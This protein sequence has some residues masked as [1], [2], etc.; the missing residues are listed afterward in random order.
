MAWGLET[1]GE[2][3]VAESRAERADEETVRAWCARVT[4]PVLV[5]QGDG[6]RVVPPEC[7][8]ALAE[9]TG[10]RLEVVEGGGHLPMV[11]DPV[12]VNLLV[13]D[14]AARF[15][16]PEPRRTW[17]RW[18]RRPRRVLYLCS[19][20]GLGHARRDVA[21][22]RELRALHP[23]VRIDWLAQDP[24]TR[25]LEAAGERVHPASRWLACES[26]HVESEAG[27]HD[28]HCFQALR[29]MDEILLANFMV[30]HDVVRDEPYDLVVGDEAWEVDHFLHENP[31][32]KRFAYAWLT[33]FVGMLP[34]PA[35]GEREA[36]V[37]ADH[38]AEMIG[39]VER[40]PRLRDRAVFVG[41]PEDVVG[42]RFGPGLPSIREWT[43]A[44]YDFAGYVTGFDPA[45][46]TDREALR[47][48]LGYRPGSRC[49]W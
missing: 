49:A 4:G 6:D 13:H 28:L 3:L 43:E 16:P 22:A 40:F 17:S 36:L 34:M 9:L 30:F 10:G 23:D 21:I 46:H 27:E 41:D 5:I 39:R 38:N 1:T 24:V 7:G 32:L 33:D 25:A 31:E 35:G 26:A 12:R 19:P 14:F 44:H 18:S 29:R 8:V 37:A 20:I 42:G 47:A 2:V 45:A 15:A 48:E 11:R